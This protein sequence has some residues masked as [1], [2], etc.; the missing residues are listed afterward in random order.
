MLQ[1]VDSRYTSWLALVGVLCKLKV[2]KVGQSIHKFSMTSLLLNSDPS[3]I[4][5]HWVQLA[6]IS[7]HV[8]YMEII[9]LARKE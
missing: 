2:I 3:L 5:P 6:T 7:L 8:E 1:T 9:P 4:K